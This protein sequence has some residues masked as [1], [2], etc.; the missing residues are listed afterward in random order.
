MHQ[1]VQLPLALDLGFPSQTEAFK[2]FVAGDVGEHRL[3]HRHAVAV[4]EF[5]FIAVDALFHPV[6]VF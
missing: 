4:D 3:D 5:A 6:S 2:A 1:A